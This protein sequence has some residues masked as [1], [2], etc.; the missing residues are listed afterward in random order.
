M[1]QA[2]PQSSGQGQQADSG[3]APFWIM[4]LVFL[5][6][7]VI[8]W[9]AHEYITAFIFKV[10]LYQAYF[11]SLFTDQLNKV[12]V[13]LETVDVSSVDWDQVTRV[14]EFVG[15]Y[16]RYPF[17]AI[18]IAFAT[19]LYFSNVTMR[20]R[21]TYSMKSL[22]EQEQE[23]WPQIKPVTQLNLVE[24]D[25]NQ[26]PWA[27]ALSPIEFA[28]KY[29]LL[30]KREIVITQLGAESPVNLRKGEARRVF[31]LQL[32]AYWSGYET[33][34]SYAKALMAVLFAKIKRDRHTSD[35]LIIQFNDSTVLGQLDFSG[36]DEIIEQYKDD[37]QITTVFQ[38]HAYFL[39]IMA[40]LLELARKD[41]V[42]PTAEFLWLKPIDRKL[43]YM[44]NSIGRQTPFVEVSGA[45]A[46]W[47]AEKELG[48]KSMVPMIEEAVKGLELA[49]RETK[50][51]PE[52]LA[53]VS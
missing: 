36:V 19:V 47:L 44:L 14:V 46:H 11:L 29:K 53:G 25:I 15:T 40:S 9:F 51:T 4:L 13:Y 34:P 30:R 12:I 6:V 1:A 10:K 35:R 21:K 49:V 31:T 37:Q 27:M 17:I 23:N 24:Q 18:L 28:F 39:T 50:L 26:G 48:R 16:L 52:Q 2:A 8:W 3:L 7:L 41:G 42:L 43:W 5:C 22:R 33:L 20:F 45:Y 38:Q 32:G